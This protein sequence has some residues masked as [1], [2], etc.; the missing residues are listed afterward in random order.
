[1][2]LTRKAYSYIYIYISF[3]MVYYYIVGVGVGVDVEGLC[4]LTREIIIKNL[5]ILKC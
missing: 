3:G 4:V 2:L 5:K 1:M